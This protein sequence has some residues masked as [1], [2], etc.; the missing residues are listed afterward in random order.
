MRNWCLGAQE[1]VELSPPVCLHEELLSVSRTVSQLIRAGGSEEVAS[2]Q[3]FHLWKDTV[4]LSM[5]ETNDVHADAS[6]T[7]QFKA[8]SR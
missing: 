1:V 3:P 8:V 4:P 5:S 6:S 2:F 7:V